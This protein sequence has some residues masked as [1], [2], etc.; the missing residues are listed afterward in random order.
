MIDLLSYVRSKDT[1]TVFDHHVG[2]F[3]SHRFRCISV[4]LRTPGETALLPCDPVQRAWNPRRLDHAFLHHVLEVDE[5]VPTNFGVMLVVQGVEDDSLL[6]QFLYDDNRLGVI[7][8]KDQEEWRMMAE[9]AL[10]Q[11]KRMPG[12]T[13]MDG[14]PRHEQYRECFSWVLPLEVSCH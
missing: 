8:A 7:R 5:A 10:K 4:A 3:V 6:E 9:V 13:F 14:E 12:K 11:S 2:Y 1:E